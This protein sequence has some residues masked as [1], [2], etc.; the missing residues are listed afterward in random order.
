[1]TST[2][3]VDLKVPYAEK[4]QAKFQGAR[5][6]Q[7]NQTWYAPPG[8]DL[9]NL[10]RWMPAG[11]LPPARE[12]SLLSSQ[13][14]ERGIALTD[15]LDRVKGVI[16]DSFPTAEWVRAEISELRGKNGHVYLTLIERNERG[17][18]V[19]QLKGIIWRNRADSLATKFEQAT[20]AGLTADIKIL[21][22]ARVR[23]DPLYGLDLIIEDVD[24]SVRPK[25]ATLD[26]GG[27]RSR[28]CLESRDVGRP[29]RLPPRSRPA[30]DCSIVRIPSLL[31]DVPGY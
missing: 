4:D 9:E 24:P 16:N 17:D 7:V 20:G 2:T 3:R 22:L 11:Q 28:G 13:D 5:W 10:M 8:T 26:P 1:M 25:S 27:I 21:C 15:L 12:R 18:I 29:G 23:F 6:D 14:S 30:P 19:A 31:G